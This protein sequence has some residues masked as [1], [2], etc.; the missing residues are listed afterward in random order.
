MRRGYVVILIAGLNL[1]ALLLELSAHRV[2]FRAGERIELGEHHAYQQKGGRC[3]SG[4]HT[5]QW[6]GEG[7]AKTV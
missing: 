4:Q 1:L 7:C 6:G 3:H 5:S 2:V